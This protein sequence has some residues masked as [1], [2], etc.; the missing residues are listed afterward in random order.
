MHLLNEATAYK[1][2]LIPVDEC[3]N[4]S[5]VREQ[6]GMSFFHQQVTHCPQEPIGRLGAD[7]QVGVKILMKH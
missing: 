4:E 2:L 6:A 3:G 5:F 7:R 1:T